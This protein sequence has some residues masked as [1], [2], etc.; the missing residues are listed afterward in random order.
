MKYLLTISLALLAITSCK[1][2]KAHI[3]SKAV[4]IK[5]EPSSYRSMDSIDN[6][7][8]DIKFIPIGTSDTNLI[9][10]IEKISIAGDKFVLLDNLGNGSIK[11]ISDK[12]KILQT[13]TYQEKKKITDFVVNNDKL[14]VY[15][16]LDRKIDIFDLTGHFIQSKMLSRNLL[17]TKMEHLD[18]QSYAFWSG[19]TLNKDGY[20]RML[21]YDRF[22]E[23]SDGFFPITAKIGGNTGTLNMYPFYAIAPD[24][25]N[26]CFPLCD[27]I[28]TLFHDK[29]TTDLYPK[30]YISFTDNPLPKNYIN[31]PDIVYYLISACDHRY[32]FFMG[33]FMEFGSNI[34]FGDIVSGIKFYGIWDKQANKMVTNA[35]R[36]KLHNLDLEIPMNTIQQIGKDKALVYYYPYLLMEWAAAHKDAANNKYVKEL[37]ALCKKL[38]KL[39]NPILA[40]ITIK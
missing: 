21:V 23:L 9:G 40:Q 17:A 10:N 27:T 39:D 35:A 37:L 7:I 13:I 25:L 20:Y 30:Y 26:V 12:G 38:K 24:Q 36:C 8:S 29:E 22:N 2:K 4:T 19:T 28:F 11:I 6:I 32:S 33:P 3:H 16:E 31:D 14:E 18:N 34:I 15:L 5:I 1:E